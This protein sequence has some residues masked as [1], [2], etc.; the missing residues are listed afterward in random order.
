MGP[1]FLIRWAPNTI[2]KQPPLLSGSWISC[3][4]GWVMRDIFMQ[5]LDIRNQLDGSWKYVL[6][7]WSFF[8]YVRVF[9]WNRESN[10]SRSFCMVNRHIQLNNKAGFTKGIFQNSNNLSWISEL[11]VFN[12]KLYKFTI[13][14]LNPNLKQPRSEVGFLYLPG[15]ELF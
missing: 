4:V 15:S 14:N 2:L 6:D 8:F 3:L 12:L 11:S 10:S 9:T 1:P 5:L 7:I 13:T